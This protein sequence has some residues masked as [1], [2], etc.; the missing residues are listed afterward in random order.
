MQAG[1]NQI[2]KAAVGAS[3]RVQILVW[4]VKL[5]VKTFSYRRFWVQRRLSLPIFHPK[6]LSRLGVVILDLHI[7]AEVILVINAIAIELHSWVQLLTMG[8]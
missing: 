4:N 3:V 2:R 8:N 6:G 5:L 7:L 1:H